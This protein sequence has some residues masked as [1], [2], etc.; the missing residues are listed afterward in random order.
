M[1]DTI[2][3]KQPNTHAAEP[4]QTSENQHTETMNTET[5]NTETMNTETMNTDNQYIEQI[6]QLQQ[7]APQRFAKYTTGDTDVC[8]TK[9][10]CAGL[11][12]TVSPISPPSPGASSA[13][14]NTLTLCIQ[15]DPCCRTRKEIMLRE[16]PIY[17]E[18]C[19]RWTQRRELLNKRTLNALLYQCKSVEVLAKYLNCSKQQVYAAMDFHNIPRAR[20]S[21]SIRMKR[22]LGL[23]E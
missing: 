9:E 19:A 14:P 16:A 8:Y 18:K 20:Y 23:R 17:P 7:N 15:S 5:M 12:Q 11:P 6:D 22:S 13:E 3:S 1:E 21:T 4:E 10:P 2:H